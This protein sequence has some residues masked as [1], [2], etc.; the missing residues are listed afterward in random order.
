MKY[1]KLYPDGSRKQVRVNYPLPAL[2]TTDNYFSGVY[3]IH[4]APNDWILGIEHEDKLYMYVRCLG[5]TLKHIHGPISYMDAL[6][7]IFWFH[8]SNMDRF[9]HLAQLPEG[10]NKTYLIELNE[11]NG[12]HVENL[13]TFNPSTKL[14]ACCVEATQIIS[15]REIE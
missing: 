15:V 7:S 10:L 2:P 12:Y 5:S 6:G 13:Q 14:E 9:G 3:D 1:M 8:R 11:F 4:Q